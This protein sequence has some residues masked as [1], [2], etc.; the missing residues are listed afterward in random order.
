MARVS[1]LCVDVEEGSQ[2]FRIGKIKEDAEGVTRRLEESRGRAQ[3]GNVEHGRVGG[4][5]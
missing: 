2:A 5:V 4:I 1:Y 3:V